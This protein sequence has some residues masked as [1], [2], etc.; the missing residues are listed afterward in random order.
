M[1]K[2]LFIMYNFWCCQILVH[3][4]LYAFQLGYISNLMIHLSVFSGH[5]EP[6]QCG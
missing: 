2:E 1:L 5:L 3:V 4:E 6:L